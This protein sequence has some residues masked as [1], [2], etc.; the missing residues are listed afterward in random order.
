[1]RRADGPIHAPLSRCPG[2]GGWVWLIHKYG[3][4]TCQVYWAQHG[5]V[6]TPIMDANRRVADDG[7]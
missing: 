3:C 4:R 6:S 1:M 5:V 2:C 7:D